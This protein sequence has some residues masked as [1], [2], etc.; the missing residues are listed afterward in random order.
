MHKNTLGIG[1]ALALGM[2]GCGE[3]DIGGDHGNADSVG[4]STVALYTGI[5]TGTGTVIGTGGINCSSSN[6]IYQETVGSTV[7]LSV[8]Q[9]ANW[10]GWYG[11]WCVNQ[12]PCPASMTQSHQVYALMDCVPGRHDCGCPGEQCCDDT[13]CGS[14]LSCNYDIWSA[15]NLCQQ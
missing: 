13:T 11:G 7:S 12:Y 1:F 6:C 3:G 4:Y 9:P 14:G 5:A 8:T 2:V 10:R 15:Q